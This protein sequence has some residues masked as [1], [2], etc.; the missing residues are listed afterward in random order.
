MQAKKIVS[1]SIRRMSTRELHTEEGEYEGEVGVKLSGLISCGHCTRELL[2]LT[3]GKQHI[4]ARCQLEC[5][6]AE[7]W[8]YERRAGRTE[9]VESL[10][11][12]PD[13]DDGE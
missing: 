3:L 13:G 7:E 11:K 10:R 9:S 4:C 2:T 1:I 6:I 8:V 12:A 5:Q